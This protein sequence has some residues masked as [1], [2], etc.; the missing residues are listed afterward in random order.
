MN[1]KGFYQDIIKELYSNG[2]FIAISDG[3]L[4]LVEYHTLKAGGMS[5]DGAKPLTLTNAFN[6]DQEYE[7]GNLNTKNRTNRTYHFYIEEYRKFGPCGVFGPREIA[8]HNLYTPKNKERIFKGFCTG[9]DCIIDA[10][11]LKTG[12]INLKG[13][14]TRLVNM[15]ENVLFT[16]ELLEKNRLPYEIVIDFEA[17]ITRIA[18]AFPKR[19]KLNTIEDVRNYSYTHPLSIGTEYPGIA[20]SV[21]RSFDIKASPEY[22]TRSVEGGTGIY[23][24]GILEIIETGNSLYNN[25]LKAVYPVIMKSNLVLVVHKKYLDEMT[26]FIEQW[27]KNVEQTKKCMPNLFQD[28]HDPIKSGLIDEHAK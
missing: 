2:G 7:L 14:S 24:D 4:A 6:R 11:E 12:D 22:V 17:P 27:K 20:Q 16:Q 18:L 9:I 23:Y 26:D 21:L 15:K 3:N 1:D 10:I 8:I 5:A 13:E 28:K 25:N 19:M